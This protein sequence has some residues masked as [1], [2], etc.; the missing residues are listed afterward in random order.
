[1]GRSRRHP[2]PLRFLRPAFGVAEKRLDMGREGRK[3]EGGKTGRFCWGFRGPDATRQNPST[4]RHDCKVED[5][6][7]NSDLPDFPTSCF[8]CLRL[9]LRLRLRL[10]LCLPLCLPLP[11]PLLC[12]I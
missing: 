9:R 11:L 2:R 4:Q 7:L 1:M 5:P 12:P 10:P 3:Q 8:P 6:I